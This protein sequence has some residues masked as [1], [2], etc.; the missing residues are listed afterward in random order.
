MSDPARGVV[1]AAVGATG[2]APLIIADARALIADPAASAA[3]IDA[4]HLVDDPY[5]RQVHMV[6]LKRAIAQIQ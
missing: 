5:E 1:R 6:A 2:G 4:S 3:V